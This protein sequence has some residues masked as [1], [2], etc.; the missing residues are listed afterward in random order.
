MQLLNSTHLT[1]PL[2]CRLFF[3]LFL[4]LLAGIPLIFGSAQARQ[5]SNNLEHFPV[6]V[7]SEGSEVDIRVRVNAMQAP[8]YVRVYYR[9]LG[10]QNFKF[11]TLDRSAGEYQGVIPANAV[12]TPVLQYFLMVLYTNRAI[13]TLPALNPYGQPM[14]IIVGEGKGQPAQRTQQRSTQPSRPAAPAQLQPGSSSQTTAFILSPDPLAEIGS[15]EVL[16]AAG[17]GGG[18]SGVDPTSVR[19]EVDGRDYTKLADISEFAVSLSPRRVARGSH[20][21]TLSARDKQGNLIPSLVWRFIVTAGKQAREMVERK[22][23]QGRVYAEFRQEKFSNQELNSNNLG[24]SLYGESGAFEYSAQAYFSQLEDPRLQPRNRFS[25]NVKH[26]LFEFGV[27][28]QYPYL[29]ELVL[30]GRRI[31]GFTG[32]IKLGFLNFE[33]ASGQSVRQIDA[34]YSSATPGLMLV[35]GTFGQ[36]LTANRLSFGRGNTFQLGFMTL[37]VRDDVNSLKPGESSTTPKDNLVGG[38]DLVIRLDSRKIEL[39][40]S[41]ASSFL[42]QD[43][44][45]GPASKA[46]IDS[47]FETDLP[48]DPASFESWL[49][50]NESTTPLDP[51]GGTALAYLVSLRLKYLRNYF[52]FGVK[53]FGREY[54]SLGQ[55]YLR[56]NLRGYYFNDRVNLFQN[57]VYMNLGV[58]NYQDNFSQDDGNPKTSLTNFNYGVTFYPRQDLPLVNFN[59]RNYV[60]NNN[61]NDFLINASPFGAP[62]TTDRREESITRDVT[63]N[64]GQNFRTGQ[65]QH[66]ATVSLINSKLI[67]EFSNTRLRTSASRDFSNFILSFAL[68]SKLS[69]ALTS[70]FSYATNNNESTR[71]L[72][73]MDFK[74]FSGRVE[75]TL[76]QQ[77]LTFYTGVRSVVSTGTR[78]SETQSIPVALIDYKQTG[79]QFGVYYVVKERHRFVI[80]ADLISFT[81]NGKT[82]NTV[83]STYVGNPSFNNRLL[84]FYYEFRI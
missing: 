5:V 75:Y 8:V 70:V 2:N 72:N 30:W 59:V 14:E 81:D 60:R 77:Q 52:Q 46:S 19:L 35:R 20:K 37:N 83:T 66:E 25:V 56:S 21:V 4:S 11:A 22:N 64:V 15:D 80:D 55:N 50:I 29:N 53:R 39:K 76:P 67:D 18:A 78:R 24:G 73:E 12:K 34:L 36:Q 17:F 38:V 51:S 27:G 3:K 44:T 1:K 32:A 40:A 57:K 43:I 31:R 16:I 41:V 71:Q 49:I 42:T 48:F 28:D 82:L 47:T 79:F 58:E 54:V 84:R 63:V 9:S 10:D 45:N 13:E 65:V 62:D 26:K 23:Y 33:H 6:N 69:R 68:K 61:I 7:A 74:M